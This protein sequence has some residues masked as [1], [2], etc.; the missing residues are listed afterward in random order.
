MDI[1][2]T[3][4]TIDL[5]QEYL[6][7]TGWDFRREEDTLITFVYKGEWSDHR[8][9]VGEKSCVAGLVIQ[10]HSTFCVPVKYT[11]EGGDENH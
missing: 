5:I 2:Q 4:Y 6:E 8:F 3:S 10:W 9:V 7:V 11:G 1:G